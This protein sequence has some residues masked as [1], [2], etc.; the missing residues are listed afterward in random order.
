LVS[1]R[2]I[3]IYAPERVLC[4]VAYWPK[5]HLSPKKRPRWFWHWYFLITVKA[6]TYRWKLIRWT[7]R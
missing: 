3:V 6:D 4:W 5:L 2:G 7:W 1:F